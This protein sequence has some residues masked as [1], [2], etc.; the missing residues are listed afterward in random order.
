MKAKYGQQFCLYGLDIFK[1]C[2]MH[3]ASAQS[4]TKMKCFKALCPIPKSLVSFENVSI[5]IMPGFDGLVHAA[6]N[7][8][9][10]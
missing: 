9:F 7:I 6:H 4:L 3:L 2:W 8:T 10:D 1:K 5:V